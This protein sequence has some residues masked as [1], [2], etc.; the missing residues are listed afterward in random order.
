[1]EQ[2]NV[3]DECTRYER[4]LQRVSS[5][6]TIFFSELTEISYY[7]VEDNPICRPIRTDCILATGILPARFTFIYLRFI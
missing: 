1:M 4:R 5:N 3:D 7:K 6:L 2:Q